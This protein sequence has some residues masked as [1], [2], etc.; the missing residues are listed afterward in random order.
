MN[1]NKNKLE[2]GIKSKKLYK[3]SAL[4]II[5]RIVL[6]YNLKKFLYTHFLFE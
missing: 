6:F 2:S 5:N 3:N 1:F 4:Y